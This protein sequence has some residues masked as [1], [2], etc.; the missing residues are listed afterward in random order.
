MKK[1]LLLLA[2]FIPFLPAQA[3]VFPKPHVEFSFIYNTEEKPLIDGLH[4]E[5]IQCRDSLCLQSDPLGNYGIQKMNC[6]AGKCEATAYRFDP[7]QKLVV[8]FTDGKTRESEVFSLPS[9]LY[10]RYNVYVE[11][12]KLVVEPSNYTPSMEDWFTA[13]VWLA[14]F[15]VLLL[16]LAAAAAF[17]VY[18]QK[19]FTILYAVAIVNVL[20]TL[21]VWVVLPSYISSIFIL[22]VLCVGLESA[23]IWAL[24]KKQLSPLEALQLSF[25]TNVT[26][27]AL[28]MIIA[29][30]FA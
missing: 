5:Q 17:L 14:L 13:D 11:P 7:Y 30:I 12:D 8:S 24:N 21:L 16:E 25:A 28:G 6:G 4:S 3:D 15:L 19:L 1:L 23:G 29:F 20:T 2:L 27:Y 22:W 26:S 18:K 10:T 9:A